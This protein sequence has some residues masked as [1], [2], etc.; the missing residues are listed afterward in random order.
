[1]NLRFWPRHKKRK[2]EGNGLFASL[3]E[4]AGMRRWVHYARHFNRQ[5]TFSARSGDIKSVF[6]GRGMEFEEIRAYN[7]GDDVRDIDW[8]VTARKQQP[9]TKIFAEERDL[10]IDIWLDLSAPMLFGTRKELK[11]VTA[12]KF[13]ALIGWLALEKK[14]RFGAMIFDGTKTFWFKP[15]SGRAQ[16]SAVFKKIAAIG[17]DV[18]QKSRYDAGE[19]KKSFRQMEQCAGN[20]ATI[21]VISGFGGNFAQMRSE[22]G[23]LAKRHRLCL[24]DVYDILE[25]KAPKAGE[26]LAQYDGQKLI[27]DSRSRDYRR[28][29]EKY[30][31]EKRREQIDFCRCND[32]RRIELRTGTDFYEAVSAL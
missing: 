31:A 27:F 11:S 20:R 16:L 23:L 30:F 8:R 4:L 2:E 3:E 5:K 13:A 9:Y 12:A 28:N 29:Y 32:C 15:Q 7:F 26:Y 19:L 25:E 24:V 14:D 22:L 1:M 6:K 10:E 18:L 17:R 21:F